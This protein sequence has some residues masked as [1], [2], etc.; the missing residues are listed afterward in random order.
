MLRSRTRLRAG[1]GS[2]TDAD[3]A[4]WASAVT[5]N[6]GTYSAATLSAVSAFCVSAKASGYWDKLNRIN[7]FCGDQLAAA[8]VPLKAGGGN[9]TDTNVNFVSGDYT[10]AT[11]IT[12]NGTTKYLNTGLVANTLTANSTH[13]AVYNRAGA[14]T[15][16]NRSIGCNDAATNMFGL[17]AP[18]SDGN[19]YSDQYS[20]AAG[21]RVSGAVSAPYGLMVGSRVSATDHKTYKAGSQVATQATSAGTLQALAI[22]VFAT[23]NNGTAGNFVAQ[24]L[25]AYSI[26]AGL[27]S[28]DVTAYN[29][30]MEAFQDAL[31]RGVQ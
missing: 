15:G 2:S 27:T 18:F 17:Y 29:T 24:P 7:L 23:N 9:A 11:G 5:A 30:H 13:L 16:G 4:A 21:G 8:L 20:G 28:A 6:S 14:V 10:E 1:G 12:G 19:M 22:Y 31:S 26:G 25:A 3:A